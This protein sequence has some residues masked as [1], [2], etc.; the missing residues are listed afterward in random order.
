MYDSTQRYSSKFMKK[1]T[2]RKYYGSLKIFW[3]AIP[4][5]LILWSG[6]QDFGILP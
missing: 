1:Q 6:L 4:E 3:L 5:I 2:L